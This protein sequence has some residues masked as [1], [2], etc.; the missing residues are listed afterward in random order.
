MTANEFAEKV[1]N[2]IGKEVFCFSDCYYN[3]VVHGKICGFA[4]RGEYP[5]FL[6]TCDNGKSY[7]VPVGFICESPD[8]VGVKYANGQDKRVYPLPSTILRPNDYF[9][10]DDDIKPL[11]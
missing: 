6:F 3:T 7:W 2:Y 4:A 1:R 5:R 10:W 11:M 9:K 8:V